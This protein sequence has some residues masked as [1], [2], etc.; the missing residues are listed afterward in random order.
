MAQ[1]HKNGHEEM[2]LLLPEITA[3]KQPA[4]IIAR[5][6]IY[7]PARQLIITYNNST[8]TILLIK[9]VERSHNFER[10]QYSVIS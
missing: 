6:G 5:V 9:I 2:I 8:H 10:I 1:I 7:E 4:T 3:V